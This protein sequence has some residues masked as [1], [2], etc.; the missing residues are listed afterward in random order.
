M[1]PPLAGQMLQT[2]KH[3]QP[4]KPHINDRF[5]WFLFKGVRDRNISGI[6]GQPQ[7]YGNF[8]ASL[9]YQRPCLKDKNET[10]F[11]YLFLYK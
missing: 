4:A 1:G 5:F 10:F 11:C 9:G 6:Q 3:Y 8:Q 2:I 7:V